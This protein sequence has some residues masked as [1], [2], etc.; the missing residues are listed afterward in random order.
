MFVKPLALRIWLPLENT[1]FYHN[2]LFVWSQDTSGC[3]WQK[4][5]TNGLNKMGRY[6]LIYRNKKSR[7][8]WNFMHDQIQVRRHSPETR[9]KLILF[10][11]QPF[12]VGIMMGTGSFDSPK[13]IGK[14]HPW[15]RQRTHQFSHWLGLDRVSVPE[16]GCV[17]G[18]SGK[19]VGIE[20]PGYPRSGDLG[21]APSDLTDS[22]KRE[23]QRGESP[24]RQ[25]HRR[26]VHI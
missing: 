17:S 9:L 16:P 20:Y 23:M 1:C 10:R 26:P 14:E 15:F 13:L 7:S 11:G 4:V 21:S 8:K 3:K 24:G 22:K 19:S 12:P 2:L 25:N 18:E 5:N 6:L